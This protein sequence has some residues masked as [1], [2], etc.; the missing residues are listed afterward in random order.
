[1]ITTA[2]TELGH[3]IHD[4]IECGKDVIG[5]L[6]LGDGRPAHGCISH[7]HAR[8]AILAQWG[9]KYTMRA[10]FV[11]QV[12]RT[13][14]DASES[15]ILAEDYRG[16]VGPHCRAHGDI[17][18]REEIESRCRTERVVV[19]LVDDGGERWRKDPRRRRRRCSALI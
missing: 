11:E 14:K 19:G 5:K 10:E 9:I 2:I 1:L 16:V 12:L 4:L 18:G 7:G 6:Y 17:D 8:D 3:F 15:D 13:A